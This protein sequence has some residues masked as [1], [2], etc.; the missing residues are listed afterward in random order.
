MARTKRA[1]SGTTVEPRIV[2]VRMR[3][4]LHERLLDAAYLRRMSMNEFCVRALEAAS[5]KVLG[6][7]TDE[8]I[9]SLADN[10]R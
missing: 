5:A 7:H 2:T 3:V 4:R 6:E 10:G 8:T 1:N 9:P